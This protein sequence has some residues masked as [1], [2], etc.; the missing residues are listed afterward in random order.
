MLNRNGCI[1]YLFCYQETVC[2]EK[3]LFIKNV[4][5][6]SHILGSKVKRDVNADQR[7][8][9]V[10]FCLLFAHILDYLMLEKYC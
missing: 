2:F 1:V 4:K 10:G 3:A 8:T 5:R 9:S 6:I 7:F